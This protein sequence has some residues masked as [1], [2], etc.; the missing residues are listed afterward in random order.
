MDHYFLW[1]GIS[2]AINDVIPDSIGFTHKQSIVITSSVI[3][4]NVYTYNLIIHNQP[5]VIKY[6][7]DNN[8]FV[9]GTLD[10][11]IDDVFTHYTIIRHRNLFKA[12]KNKAECVE[13]FP[14]NHKHILSVFKHGN[15]KS[16]IGNMTV[17]KQR[18]NTE[19]SEVLDI[20][21]ITISV[22]SNYRHKFT[23]LD[24]LALFAVNGS[25]QHITAIHKDVVKMES[26][27]Q[28]LLIYTDPEDEVIVLYDIDHKKNIGSILVINSDFKQEY[29]YKIENDLYHIGE[30]VL[31]RKQEEVL[32]RKFSC[33]IKDN[34][35]SVVDGNV[36]E[37]SLTNNNI[38]FH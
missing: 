23:D 26:K 14:I 6:T 21:S 9:F 37:I 4:A 11:V 35:L 13:F 19:N 17:I 25:V 1:Y 33:V 5:V 30:Y 22:P 20:E 7:F 24:Y 8:N 15:K 29:R 32:K 38:L 2:L 31:N 10:I 16:R 3:Q 18:V 34:N 12:Y 36:Y 28:K 27:R